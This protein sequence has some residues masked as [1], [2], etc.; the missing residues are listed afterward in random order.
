VFASVHAARDPPPPRLTAPR[1]RAPAPAGKQLHVG[2][3]LEVR[4]HVTSDSKEGAAIL[5][6]LDRVQGCF[7]KVKYVDGE[8]F[9]GGI[10]SA[11]NDPAVVAARDKMNSVFAFGAKEH[12]CHV[13]MDSIRNQ[14]FDTRLN[15]ELKA[16]T[17]ALKSTMAKAGMSGS[18]GR[19]GS[20]SPLPSSSP[21]S[22]GGTARAYAHAHA[23]DQVRDERD[24]KAIY[25][26]SR[27][28]RADHVFTY[29]GLATANSLAAEDC[30]GAQLSTPEKAHFNATQEFLRAV[31][32]SP[33]GLGKSTLLWREV[34]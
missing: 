23:F 27:M 17:A 8:P 11:R 4:R 1:P 12:A 18:L 29:G 26:T 2:N 22:P 28:G 13:T 3:P 30:V 24:V 15:S 5:A 7:E 6:N 16:N 10:T 25:G 9:V 20:A 32:G 14:Q 31:G 34:V 33:S 19:E 21:P